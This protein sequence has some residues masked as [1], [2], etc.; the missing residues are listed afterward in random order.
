MYILYSVLALGAVALYLFLPTGRPATSSIRWSGRILAIAALASLAVCWTRWINPAIEGRAFFVIFAVI[1]VV[2][3]A[4]V[5]SHPKPIY[6]ALYFILVVLSVAALCILAAADFL[7]VALVIVYAGA[8][9]VTYVFVIM[10][11]QQSSAPLSDRTSR[12]PVAAVSLA[13]LLVAAVTQAMAA[14]DPIIFGAR[15]AGTASITTVSARPAGQGEPAALA[16]AGG[17]PGMNPKT[18]DRAEGNVRAIGET[19]MT[20]Y[21]LAVETAGV[22]LLVALVGAVAMAHKRIEPEAMTPEELAALNTT[23]DIRRRG[24]EAPPF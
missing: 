2:A 10:L 19:L 7:A 18:A 21:V 23:E 9:L 14:P 8:I 15:R 24:R 16:T 13:F 3:A 4:R 17:L 5:V 6:C 22:L 12:E 1:A 11:A 20:T